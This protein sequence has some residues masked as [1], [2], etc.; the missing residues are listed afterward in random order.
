M[1]QQTL[2]I[3][4][5]VSIR[6]VVLT[7]LLCRQR[8]SAAVAAKPCGPHTM[9]V[10]PL[11]ICCPAAHQFVQ[12]FSWA[13]A[14]R[15]KARAQRAQLVII[16]VVQHKAAALKPR[17]RPKR[18][19][20]CSSSLSCWECWGRWEC[21]GTCC[22]RAASPQGRLLLLRGGT[23]AA[24]CG[25]CAGGA[26]QAAQQLPRSLAQHRGP[27]AEGAIHCPHACSTEGAG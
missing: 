17:C 27:A 5:R 15:R 6:R 11:C 12:A 16:D 3:H 9:R 10:Q 25:C 1:L 23:A 19:A 14:H 2:C 8:R 18:A 24:Q 20:T 21:G 26:Q 4:S 7:S 22:C 13:H